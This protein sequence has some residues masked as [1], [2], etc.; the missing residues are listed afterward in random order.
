[1]LV[2]GKQGACCNYA[3]GRIDDI[4]LLNDS[5]ERI[6]ILAEDCN[7]LQGFMVLHSISGGT[8]SGYTSLLLQNL[9][10]EYAGKL[11][12]GIEV[13]PTQ[14]SP[15]TKMDTYNAVLSTNTL[16]NDIDISFVLDNEAITNICYNHLS[17]K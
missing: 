14:T 12:I 16:L 2:S 13:F 17:I 8:G 5:L 11:K 9:S 1:M 10:A 15:A 3:R 7:N 6:R 4:K